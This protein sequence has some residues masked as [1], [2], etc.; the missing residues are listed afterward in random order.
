VKAKKV[1]AKKG[2]HA[3]TQ[4]AKKKT[5][6]LRGGKNSR[7][8][9]KKKNPV[10]RLSQKR[11]GK[12]FWKTPR[13]VT[14]QANLGKKKTFQRKSCGRPLNKKGLKGKRFGG[15]NAVIEVTNPGGKK[16]NIIFDGQIREPVGAGLL[17]VPRGRGGEGLA[18]GSKRTLGNSKSSRAENLKK[19]D[20]PVR[21]E[22]EKPG[23]QTSSTLNGEI[24]IEGEDPYKKTPQKKNPS[25]KKG[26]ADSRN[27]RIPEMLTR[28]ER[29]KEMAERT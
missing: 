14:G 22:G 24:I 9:Q 7:E 12:S 13:R 26:R 16:D 17:R 25:R 23:L 1:P 20:L 2:E 27:P 4:N 18:A 5:D 3:G 21:E 10:Q 11:R 8:H 28:P 19:K 15:P 6:R 29:P